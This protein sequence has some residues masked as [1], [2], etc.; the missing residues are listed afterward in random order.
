[1]TRN[2]TSL[3]YLNYKC[4]YFILIIF[5]LLS[6]SCSTQDLSYF[7][8]KEGYKWRYNVIQ[9]TRDGIQKQQYILRNF[10]ETEIND[11]PAFVRYSLDGTALYYSISDEGILY[12]GST[13]GQDINL[14]FNEDEQI[15]I[16]NPVSVDTYWEQ[17]TITKLLKKTGPPQKT[18]FIIYAKVP[19]EVKI[20]SLD[21]V[22]DVSAGRFENCMKISM[23]GSA[24]KDAGNY[25]GMT[26][27]NVEQTSWY[28]KGVGLVKMERVETTQSEALDKGSLLIELAEYKSG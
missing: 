7:P 19:L 16:R 12:L 28:A 8:L 14:E 13:N 22:V 26:L 4:S 25:V 17:S 2:K 5:A 3:L 1:M 18:E 20:E 11:K 27:V 15:V 21:E 23:S 6:S 24:F 10:G 9:T